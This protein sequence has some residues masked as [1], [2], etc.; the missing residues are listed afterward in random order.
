MEVVHPP[1]SRPGFGSDIKTLILQKEKELHDIN[2]YRIRALEEL[3]QKKDAELEDLRTK[4]SQIKDDF[5]FNL[6]LIQQRDEELDTCETEL[7]RT[8]QSES[9]LRAE[10]EQ[11]KVQLSNSKA[12]HEADKIKLTET[13]AWYKQQLDA[14]QAQISSSNSARAE[15]KRSWSSQLESVRVEAQARRRA[16]EVETEQKLA[17]MHEAAEAAM[18]QSQRESKKREERAVQALH[19]AESRAQE[20]SIHASE[21]RREVAVLSAA[22]EGARAA[23]RQAEADASQA[24]TSLDTARAA[25]ESRLASVERERDIAVSG[26]ASLLEEY[27][28]R[29]NGLLASLKQVE[30]AFKEQKRE[31]EGRLTEISSK[32]SAE[33]RHQSSEWASKESDLLS[34]LR[35]CE[36][37]C[38]LVGARERE[39][40]QQVQELQQRVTRA[41]R[42]LSERDV[43]L[44]STREELASLSVRAS[45][46]LSSAHARLHEAMDTGIGGQGVTAHIRADLAAALTRAEKAESQLRSIDSSWESRWSGREAELRGAHAT[47]VLTLQQHVDRLT[48]Q[49][50][51]Q[52]ERGQPISN[53]ADSSLSGADAVLSPSAGGSAS[54]LDPVLLLHQLESMDGEL[55]QAKEDARAARQALASASDEDNPLILSLRMELSAARA[56]AAGH[57]AGEDKLRSVVTEMREHIE[58]LQ[59][60]YKQVQEQLHA[61]TRA[62]EVQQQTDS[63]IPATSAAPALVPM[64]MADALAYKASAESMLASLKKE[65]DDVQADLSKAHAYIRVLQARTAVVTDGQGDKDAVAAST[66]GSLQEECTLLRDQLHGEQEALSSLRVR[67]RECEARVALHQGH[68]ELRAQYEEEVVALQGRVQELVEEREKLLELSNSLRGQLLRL[69]GSAGPSRQLAAAPAPARPVP[70]IDAGTLERVGHLEASLARVTG[71]N[72]ALHADMQRLMTSM[73]KQSKAA[74]HSAVS[75][76]PVVSHAPQAPVHAQLLGQGQGKGS[77]Q[78]E[79][80]VD[81]A[82]SANPWTHS[83][84]APSL[85]VVGVAA[86]AGQASGGLARSSRGAAARPSTASSSIGR[87]SAVKKSST[88]AYDGSGRLVV[89]SSGSVHAGSV[90][91]RSVLEAK[92]AQ[93]GITGGRAG[94]AGGAPAWLKPA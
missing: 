47:E 42:L 69:Q 5:Q 56:E 7:A 14:L 49:M 74:S 20:A 24:R 62:R 11:L 70:M 60:A 39:A 63:A 65:R 31:Y 59:E 8:K 50:Q 21:A 80:T 79:K 10:L 92:A 67:L 35:E 51:G 1:S 61:E 44:Q 27:E 83:S 85:G 81:L 23:T 87:V 43:E 32:S 76:A 52:K 12:G 19:A 88:S 29:M 91:P 75:D 90:Q 94:T 68:D 28:A 86:V 78:K 55:Q 6:D 38:R 84:D 13:Q 26:R 41:E 48:R 30:G 40:T 36:H 16:M 72:A 58:E 71:Q 54:G 46:Q 3:C 57:A 33:L 4:F 77:E 37:E 93:A 82:A 89:S 9:G 45:S 64:A 53:S 34:R 2:E 22:L 66:Q 25:F 18:T 15:E 17:E 73:D